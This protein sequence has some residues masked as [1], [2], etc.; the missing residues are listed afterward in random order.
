MVSS[1]CYLSDPTRRTWRPS[2]GKNPE[3]TP[4][5]ALTE[6]FWARPCLANIVIDGMSRL[7]LTDVADTGST[8]QGV[9]F[10]REFGNRARYI[11]V[12]RSTG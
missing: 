9:V 2:A 8:C 7:R 1:M 10:P 6:A 11:G 5:F 4:P 12:Y 3:L